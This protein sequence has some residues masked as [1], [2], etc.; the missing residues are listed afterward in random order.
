MKILQNKK[1]IILIDIYLVYFFIKI[2]KKNEWNKWNS[3]ISKYKW[4]L[5]GKVKA[6]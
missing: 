4:E 1:R 5:S 2:I 6:F 3:N